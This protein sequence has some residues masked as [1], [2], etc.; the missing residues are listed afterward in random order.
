M[1]LRS[2]NVLKVHRKST[3][4]YFAS[5]FAPSGPRQF[6]ILSAI[7]WDARIANFKTSL[8]LALFAL[9]TS[10]AA[11]AACWQNEID[12][13]LNL[14]FSS[15]KA[16]NQ[17][18][19]DWQSEKPKAPSIFQLAI[20][21]NIY[22]SEKNNSLKLGSDKR[23]HCYMGCRIAQGTSVKTAIYSGWKKE[24][25]DIRD[26]DMNSRYEPLDYDATE[27]GALASETIANSQSACAKYCTDNVLFAPMFF[28]L[29]TPDL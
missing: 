6:R 26:C 8:T 24:D 20:A 29:D 9:C 13:A 7:L 23:A 25:Q 22:Q 1:K 21:Y 12:P 18:V 17:T 3:I 2:T 10:N 27:L 14:I 28:D 11:F 5:L 4:S 19:A 15:E 16:Y